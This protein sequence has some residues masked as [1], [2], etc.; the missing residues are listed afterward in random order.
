MDTQ[1]QTL[2]AESLSQL[3]SPRVGTDKSLVD[4]NLGTTLM[5]EIEKGR[6]FFN[7][8]TLAGAHADALL[9]PLQESNAYSAS[10]NLT[11]GS[12]VYRARTK[13]KQQQQQ[14]CL[15]VW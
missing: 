1:Q 3:Q 2:A 9:C 10:Q 14:Q 15:P 6:L 8:L 12:S 7:G 5:G 11:S 13:K 4:T